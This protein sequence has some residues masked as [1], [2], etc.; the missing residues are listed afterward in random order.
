M[1]GVSNTGAAGTGRAPQPDAEAVRVRET[2]R[3][4]YADHCAACHGAAARGDGPA[5]ASLRRPPTDL[6]R[7]ARANGGVFP[8]E[9]LRTVVDGR[10]VG[11]HGSVEMPV[12]GSVFKAAAGSESAARSRIEAIVAYLR[13]LQERPGDDR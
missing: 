3:Q 13:S 12:W 6:T 9:R 11:A 4:L 8:A 2:G 5:A 10:G 7:Y 1:L